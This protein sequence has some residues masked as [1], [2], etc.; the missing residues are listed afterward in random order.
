MRDVLPIANMD[1][2]TRGYERARIELQIRGQV[3]SPIWR[4]RSESLK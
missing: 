4:P 3:V 2:S 1:M